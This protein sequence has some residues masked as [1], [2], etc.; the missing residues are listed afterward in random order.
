MMK[1]DEKNG[2]DWQ[3][4]SRILEIMSFLDG[5]EESAPD[6][7][8]NT[9][10]TFCELPANPGQSMS[11]EEVVFWAGVATGMEFAKHAEEETIDP[12]TADKLLVFSSIFSHSTKSAI[13]D[14]ALGQLEP[15]ANQV[16]DGRR[17]EYKLRRS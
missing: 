16:G 11:L 8:R 4:F 3:G 1:L 9:A 13:V 12:E 7:I 6:D 2:T 17:A 10:Q 15:E 5:I 14:L